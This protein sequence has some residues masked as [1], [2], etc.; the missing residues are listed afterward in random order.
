ME[1]RMNPRAL[2]VLVLLAFLSVPATTSAKET[3]SL[4]DVLMTLEEPFKAKS[5][6]SSAIADFQ[7]DFFQESRVASLDRVQKG[8]GRVTVKF[9]RSRSERVARLLFRWE[10]EQPTRQEIVSNGK[11]M[12][13]YVP[14]NHQVIQ[15]DIETAAQPRADDPLAF[16]TGLGNLSRDF[17]IAWASPN[18]DE[19]GNPVLELRPRQT[20]AMLQ[21][22]L[23]VVSQ[24]A[25]AEQTRRGKPTSIFPIL[26]TTV[27]DLSD[28]STRIEF[29]GVKVNRRLPDSFFDFVTPGGV[30]VVRPNGQ[31]MG[32]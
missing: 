6:T 9:D 8:R 26:A 13:V 29:S 27:Y 19:Q 10:Y 1:K 12:W 16:L 21:K 7:A 20:S 23:V 3:V 11:T 5:A 32:F 15:S 30:E 22:L 31:G 28:N 17:V 25:V 2:L 4:N 24:E 18:R 14:E